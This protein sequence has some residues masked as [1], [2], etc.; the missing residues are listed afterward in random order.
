MLVKWSKINLK[1]KTDL[2]VA[3]KVENEDGDPNLAAEI[4]DSTEIKSTG[5]EA[6]IR[7]LKTSGN[8]V[9]G[10]FIE[11]EFRKQFA[12]AKTSSEAEAVITRFKR[13]LMTHHYRQDGS[14]KKLLKKY[15]KMHK[16]KQIFLFQKMKK[17]LL[18]EKYIVYLTRVQNL[19]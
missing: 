11:S 13:A 10:I 7:N 17:K 8:N 9:G 19:I 4:R 5:L 3:Y 18:Q 2:K 15:K 6:L 14:N 1:K 12:D 16:Y